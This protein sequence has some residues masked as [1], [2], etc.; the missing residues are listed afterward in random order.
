MNLPVQDVE[1]GGGL[2]SA[3]WTLQGSASRP[4]FVFLRAS[5]ME[6][7]THQH[8]YQP[9]TKSNKYQGYSWK[10]R[11]VKEFKHMTHI[12]LD[13]TSGKLTKHARDHS[14]LIDN[15]SSNGISLQRA[16]FS[17]HVNRCHLFREVLA[18]GENLW[19]QR[20]WCTSCLLLTRP[21][22]L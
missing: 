10:K 6:E 4:G 13:W 18:D 5:N 17:W 12:A 9:G 15:T 1:N 19:L 3:R 16:M 21:D 22:I 11:C 2:A 14:F 7:R 8:D 20:S